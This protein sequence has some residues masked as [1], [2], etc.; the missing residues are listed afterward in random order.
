M[1]ALAG[2]STGSSPQLATILHAGGMLQDALFL[3][4]PAA[5]IRAVCAPK[6]P[7]AARAVSEGQHQALRAINMFSS[8]AAYVGSAGQANYAA[9]NSALNC[10]AEVL[11]LGG[12]PGKC[13]S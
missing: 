10:W 9:A 13:L 8:V 5:G 7:F 1:A 11:Q 6:L 3:Q 4:Q 2:R 12:L